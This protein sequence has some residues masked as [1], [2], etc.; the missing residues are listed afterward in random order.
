MSAL[1]YLN[2]FSTRQLCIVKCFLFD[3]VLPGA[4]AP[5]SAWWPGAACPSQSQRTLQHEAD[6]RMTDGCSHILQL[7]SH[8]EYPFQ[9]QAHLKYGKNKHFNE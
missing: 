5:P 4:Q 3:G 2:L 6:P 9:N 7:F 8:T 1:V